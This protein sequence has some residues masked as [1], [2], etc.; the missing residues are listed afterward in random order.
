M[1]AEKLERAVGMT[2]DVMGWIFLFIYIAV[3]SP[4]LGIIY[5]Y[6]QWTQREK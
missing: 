5:L 4:I 2:F 6:L 3:A 1:R